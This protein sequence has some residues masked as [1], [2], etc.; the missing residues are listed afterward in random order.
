[1]QIPAGGPS[2]V[3]GTAFDF[4]EMKSVLQMEGGERIPFDHN[5]CL[6]SERTAKREVARLRSEKS[7][8][9]MRVLTT[10]PGVQF[11]GAFKV[12]VPVPGLEGRKYGAFSGLCLETQTWP[13]A[14][15]Q[16][17]FPKAILRP[18]EVLRQETD[19]VFAKA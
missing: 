6:S 4:R 19:Y 12:E 11:Y 1:V 14:I 2:D 18:G 3:T 5:F 9:E 16:A 10:E 8:V 13:D 15:N 17:G 7:G